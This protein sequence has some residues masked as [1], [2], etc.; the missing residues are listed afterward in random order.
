MQPKAEIV[1]LKWT[2]EQISQSVG[3]LFWN[4]K[5]KQLQLECRDHGVAQDGTLKTKLDRLRAHY[6]EPHVDATRKARTQSM[7]SFFAPSHA[8][9]VAKKP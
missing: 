7:T 2:A 3:P 5:Y 8:A 6:A 1:T 4:G 9:K